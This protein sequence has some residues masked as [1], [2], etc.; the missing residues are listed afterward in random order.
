MAGLVASNSNLRLVPTEPEPKVYEPQTVTIEETDED[1]DQPSFDAKGNVIRIDHP[2]GSVTINLDGS[3]IQGAADKGPEGW[4]SNLADD[5][6]TIELSR[7]SDE[8]IRG[9]D[10][11]KESRRDWLETRA[12]GIRLLGFKIELP[13]TQ[14]GSDSAP[15]EGM[16]KVRHPLLQEAVLRFQAN[17]SA[18]MLPVDGPVKVRIATNRSTTMD[19][20]LADA[21]E[22]DM[23]KYLTSQF[24]HRRGKPVPSLPRNA[25]GPIV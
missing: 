3:P 5:I 1:Q 10:A 17:A 19:D 18:E 22:A 9:I 8:L 7:I 13:G 24:I 15:V 16:S 23:N 2:D 20:D 6:D 21:L 11:D 14:G 12:E 4:F 25:F